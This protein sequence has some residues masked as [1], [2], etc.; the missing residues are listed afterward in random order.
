VDVGWTPEKRTNVDYFH[1][2]NF[3]I[4]T[5]R[6]TSNGLGEKIPNVFERSKSLEQL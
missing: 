6:R 5:C 4:V 2:G 3:N 1:V